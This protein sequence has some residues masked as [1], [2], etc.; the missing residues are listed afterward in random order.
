MVMDGALLMV[1][2]MFSL[3]AFDMSIG[4]IMDG[5]LLM[6]MPVFSLAAFNM[7]IGVIKTRDMF[8]L[9]LT[10]QLTNFINAPPLGVCSTAGILDFLALILLFA[11]LAFLTVVNLFAVP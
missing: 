2:P 7:S 3:A 4:V 11:I 5:A 6:A 1:M 9:A 10:M 8:V